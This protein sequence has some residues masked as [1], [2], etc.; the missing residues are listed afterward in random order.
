M[1]ILII[2]IFVIVNKKNLRCQNFC[3]ALAAASY[4]G[5]AKEMRQGQ[6]IERVKL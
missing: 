2:L 5:Q 3:P 4:E 6:R 1:L